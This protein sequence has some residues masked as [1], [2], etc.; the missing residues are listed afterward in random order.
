[1]DNTVQETAAKLKLSAATI[2]RLI[3]SREL[4]AIRSGKRKWL[5]TDEAIAEYRQRQTVTA[6]IKPGGEAEHA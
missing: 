1:V 3:Q 4:T 6:I 5:I 2:R